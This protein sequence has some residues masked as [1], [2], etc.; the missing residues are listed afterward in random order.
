MASKFFP[1]LFTGTLF[2]LS[3]SLAWG[4][5]ADYPKVEVFGGFSWLEIDA[6]GR[7]DERLYGWQASIS[8]NFHENIGIVFDVGGRYKS[9]FDISTQFYEFLAGPRFTMR[10]DEGTVFVHALAG[11]DHARLSGLGAIPFLEMG[12]VLRETV[13]AVGFGGGADINVGDWGAFRMVQIDYIGNRFADQW[14]WN[15]RA[16]MGFVFKFG[17]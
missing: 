5:E 13:F 14:N 16:G 6:D 8:G 4:Q 11:L 17:Y 9:A 2:L 1:S 10:I 7:E 3:S 15:F 12:E